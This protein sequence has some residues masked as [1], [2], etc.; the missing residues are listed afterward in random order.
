MRLTGYPDRFSARP[1]ETIR[2]HVSSQASKYRAEIVRLI[3]GDPNPIGPGL[4]VESVESPVTGEYPGVEQHLYGGSH[5]TV[6][7]S[8]CL[9]LADGFTI[10]AW[11]SPSWPDKGKP[12]ALVTKLSRDGDSGYGLF[13]SRNG[14]LALWVGDGEQSE[15][16]VTGRALRRPEWYFVAVSFDGATRTVRMNQAPL[17]WAA[18]HEAVSVGKQVPVAAIAPSG[19]P[20]MIAA[21]LDADG[22]HHKVFNGK[23]DAPRIF[24]R[25]L[26]ETEIA[27]LSRGADPVAVAGTALVASWDFS[28]GMSGQIAT[29]TSA[30]RLH[31]TVVNL[32]HRAVIGHNWSGHEYNAA[33]RPGEY[34]GIEFHEEDIDDARWDVSVEYEVPA[35]AR[36]GIFALK[37]TSG[38]AVD[39]IPFFIRPHVGKPQAKIAFLLETNTY[40]AYG[41]EHVLL[42]EGGN[43]F[44]EGLLPNW[45]KTV[46]H[47]EVGYI[48]ENGLHSMYDH[49]RDGSGVPYQT[50]KVPILNMR[51]DFIYPVRG[52]P[53]CM[54]AD[55]IIADWMEQA[56]H[57]F[58]VFSAEDLHFDG[59]ALLAPYNVLVLGSHPEYWSL[60]MLESVEAYMAQGGR[61]MYLG[62]NGFYW[63]TSFDPERP[64][65]IEIRRWGGTDVWEA[66]P[67]EYYHSTTGELG[68]IWR[69]RNRAPQKMFG[70]GFT[71]QGF[72]YNS[73]YDQMPDAR[74]PR[75]AFIFEGVGPDELIGDYP[76]L[77]LNRG[78]AGDEIDRF[79][80]ALGTPRHALL[81]ATSAGRH[82]KVY[83]HV[84]EEV[85]VT[86]SLQ[87]GEVSPFVRSDLTY[88]EGPNGG[89]VFSVGSIDWCGVLSHNDYENNVSKITG[90]VLK[91]FASDESLPP[92]P[93]S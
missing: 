51:P 36:S 87:H 28:I 24:D 67:G 26:N 25:A 92:P 63:V 80:F 18:A 53:H 54:A 43:T 57:E 40:L 61:V 48:V 55:L 65:V 8:P 38:D 90:N 56:G 44:P 12:Q 91:R 59:L 79:D 4:K 93:T 85:A 30:H 60:S 32:P 11:I 17:G 70:V 50:R 35:D 10:T 78:A 39:H 82:S 45:N 68:G 42:P 75:A 52:G 64:H 58:D 37:T 66:E 73:P 1:G 3:H 86:D 14:D 9:D 20:L 81:L 5:V 46:H 49:K 16:V 13:V 2:F 15:C 83:H 23:I 19:G 31:G 34:G 33:N 71:A 74:D 22:R 84:I 27:A 77:M 62:G 21:S 76:S 88:F 69:N 47:E 41:N 29:D 7:D 89:G 6:P 72:D